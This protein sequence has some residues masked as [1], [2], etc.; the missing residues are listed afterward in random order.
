MREIAD[1]LLSEG[2]YDN[3]YYV[4]DEI[5]NQ[6][7]NAMGSIQNGI[8]EFSQSYLSG[9]FKS[10]IEFRNDYT[11]KATASVFR[12]WFDLDV[13][14]TLNE[15]TFT[16]FGHLQCVCYSPKLNSTIPR[17]TIQNEFL[18]MHTLILENESDNWI[19]SLLKI[20][21]P[22][23]EGSNLK[24]L[25][26]NLL[27]SNTRKNI[28]ENATR[29]KQTDW[30]NVNIM[31]LDYLI[32]TG[33][34]SSPMYT[35]VNKIVGFYS[36]SKKH[37]KKSAKSADDSRGYRSGKSES[38]E[39]ERYERY[40]RFEKHS[41]SREVE[42]D[43]LSATEFEKSKYY[44]ELLG[45]KGRITKAE[46]REKYLDLISKYHPDKIFGLGDELMVLAEKK[47]KQLNLAYEWMKKKYGI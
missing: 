14:Q 46:I 33:D 10:I 17:T 37:Y 25:R 34:N 24:K 44:G 38:Y 9:S 13:D 30:F 36:K 27:E 1:T 20:A 15:F 4:Y 42:F 45:L 7:W 2:K 12:K 28:I 47:T 41:F 23:V 39:Y 35:S 32:N 22:V 16:T 21:A 40:E 5:Y 11:I 26:Y 18:T 19:T 8:S 29:I 3:A 31:L 43:P 6:I